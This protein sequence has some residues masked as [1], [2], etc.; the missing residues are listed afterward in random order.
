MSFDVEVNV[1]KRHHGLS[2]SVGVQHPRESTCVRPKPSRHFLNGN[3][4]VQ[5]SSMGF[6][7][8][9]ATAQGEHA[10]HTEAG[11][12]EGEPLVGP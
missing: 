11:Q 1:R 8:L 2:T 12:S 7:P 4:A 5:S 6:Q 3:A 10:D 9:P